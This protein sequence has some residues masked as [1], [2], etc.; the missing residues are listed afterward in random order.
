MTEEQVRSRLGQ[1]MIQV[2]LGDIRSFVYDML[3]VEFEGGRVKNVV[4]R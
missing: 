4:V 3:Q 1:P 2:V